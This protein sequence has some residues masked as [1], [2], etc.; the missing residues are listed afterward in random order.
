MINHTRLAMSV[1]VKQLA[2]LIINLITEP[3]MVKD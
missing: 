2:Y 1:A 3:A